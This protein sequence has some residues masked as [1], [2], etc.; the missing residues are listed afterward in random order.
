MGGVFGF[1]F[2]GSGRCRYLRVLLLQVLARYIGCGVRLAGK[3]TRRLQDGAAD[4]LE[5]A[6]TPIEGHQVGSAGGWVGGG[7][8]EKNRWRN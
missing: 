4:A 7:G 5:T 8:V 3:W 6:G 1:F 2:S